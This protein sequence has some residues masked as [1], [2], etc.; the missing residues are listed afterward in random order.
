MKSSH[1]CSP[2]YSQYTEKPAHVG[3]ISSTGIEIKATLALAVTILVRFAQAY[4]QAYLYSETAAAA[5]L[6]HAA[7]PGAILK[8]ELLAK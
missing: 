1:A 7:R 5:H 6:T 8:Q 4:T 2:V 3:G